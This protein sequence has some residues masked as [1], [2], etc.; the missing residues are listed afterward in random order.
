M[1]Y[2]KVLVELDSMCAVKLCQGQTLEPHAAFPLVNAIRRALSLSW[3]VHLTH[4][5]RE[6]NHCVNSFAR[7]GHRQGVHFML[8][9]SLPTFAYVAFNSD[10]MGVLP[11]ENCSCLVLFPFK[12]FSPI[13]N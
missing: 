2:R 12:L 8:F 9:S 13:V 5:F 10:L 11:L 7:E 1:G 4:V 6:S 3:M